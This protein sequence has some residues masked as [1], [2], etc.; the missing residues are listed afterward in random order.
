M[1]GAPVTG[2]LEMAHARI[3]ARW[4][5]RADA[6]Q[7]RRLEVTRELAAVLVQARGGPL[8]GWLEGLEAG[9]GLHEIDR[10]LRARWRARA[11]E[12]AGW[13]PQRWHDA[14]RACATLVDLPRWQQRVRESRAA[15]RP[16]GDLAEDPELRHWLAAASPRLAATQRRWAADLAGA[17]DRAVQAWL[18]GWTTLLPAGRESRL[19]IDRFVPELLDHRARFATADAADAGTQRLQ[20]QARLLQWM[21][22]HPVQP[23][24]AFAYLGLCAL[25]LERLRAEIVQRAAFPARGIAP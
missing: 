6:V 3:W 18:A 17:P 25:E 22:R 14:M 2:S 1:T 5:Q 10:R 24:C 11:D 20:L 16:A 4:G 7:W 21:R 23:V 13:L 19:V 8:A 15:A 12:L 9:A